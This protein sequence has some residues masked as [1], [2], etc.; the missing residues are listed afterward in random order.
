MIIT[1]HPVRCDT[2]Y[3]LIRQGDSLT[4]S[5]E[6]LDFASLAEGQTLPRAAI[7]NPWVAG[8]V[9][10]KAGA[11]HIALLL[12]HGSVAPPTTRFAD[13]VVLTT[14]GPVTLP[15]FNQPETQT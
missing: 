6:T 12:P 15:D 10:R 5:G 8:P 13:P 4:L 14:D 7:N 3:D 9:E 1:F 11:L 2:Q